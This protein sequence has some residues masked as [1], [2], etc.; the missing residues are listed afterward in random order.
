MLRIARL[1]GAFP[2]TLPP[3][4]EPSAAELARIL[5][6]FR[7]FAACHAL[8]LGREMARLHK[9]MPP[10][11]AAALLRQL[12]TEWGLTPDQIE[13]AARIAKVPPAAALVFSTVLDRIAALGEAGHAMLRPL[14]GNARG[15]LSQLFFL[16]FL[17]TV[18][19][20]PDALQAHPAPQALLDWF[21]IFGLASTGS[22]HCCRRPIGEACC[23]NERVA[24]RCSPQHC[25]GCG[26]TCGR[27]TA[28]AASPQ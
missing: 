24:P 3:D 25:C 23:W 26:P 11:E 22:G 12:G 16:L 17:A 2:A 9:A 15:G 6:G 5:H 8:E 18:L 21:V 14:F 13:A 1:A 7:G 27:C 4:S 20:R 10:P 19:R 28:A